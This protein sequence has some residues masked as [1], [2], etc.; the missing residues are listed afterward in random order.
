[1]I[2]GGG[3]KKKI[4]MEICDFFGDLVVSCD[5]LCWFVCLLETVL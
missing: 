4:E 2:G 1:V 3:I 5:V